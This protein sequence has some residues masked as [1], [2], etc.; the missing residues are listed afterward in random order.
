MSEPE[1]D[2]RDVDEAEVAVG[3]LVVASGETAR[4]L[5]LAEA[6]LDLVA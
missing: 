3:G 6:A 2:G 4:G 1:P 5:Q